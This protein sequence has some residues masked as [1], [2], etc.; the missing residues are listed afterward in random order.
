MYFFFSIC[1]SLFQFLAN[2]WILKLFSNHIKK[3]LLLIIYVYKTHNLL[4]FIS[5]I[6]NEKN[7][8]TFLLRNNIILQLAT[9]NNNR[10][11]F[12]ICN[13]LFIFYFIHIKSVPNITKFLLVIS[14]VIFSNFNIKLFCIP[15]NNFLYYIPNIKL[16]LY[17]AKLFQ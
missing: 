2:F 10:N 16:L 5:L 4:I 14:S 9:Q 1:Q 17:F 12:K 11:R 6:K 7:I 3:L 8:L 15:L 13:K